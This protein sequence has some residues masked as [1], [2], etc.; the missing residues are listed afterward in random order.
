M[1]P[2]VRYLLRVALSSSLLFTLST[3]WPLHANDL[4]TK[5][6]AENLENSLNSSNIQSLLNYLPEQD[7]LEL[8]TRYKV[9]LDAFPNAKWTIKENKSIKDRKHF[10]EISITGEKI[11]KSEKYKI[12]ATQVLAIKTMGDRLL[13]N[14]IISEQTIIQNSKIPL[15]ISINVP[16]TVLTGTTYDYDVVID[17]PL[18][19]TILIGG[20]I[21]ITKEQMR[22]QLSPPIELAPLG[23]G[24][25]FKSVKAPL[26]PGIQNWAAVI[27]HP[28]G[29]ISITKMV[30]VVSNASE[31]RL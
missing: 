23:G 28:E 8:A 6:L 24:G 16:K 27:A 25:L 17:K 20:L 22:N 9:F 12:Q 3:Q 29:L 31:I 14:K 19:N 15:A 18:G 10:L 1:R 11:I 2:K 5:S 4:G 13:S 21:P 26:N 30:R 7:K